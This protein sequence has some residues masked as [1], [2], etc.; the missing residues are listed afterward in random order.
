M[1][2]AEVLAWVVGCANP[3]SAT[4]T[5][6]LLTRM[7]VSARLARRAQGVGWAVLAVGQMA[8]LTFGLVSGLSGF[9]FAQPLMILVAGA[10]FLVWWS[11]RGGR[12]QIDKPNS[13]G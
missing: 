5:G 2:S 11:T 1:V 6:P 12:G 7:G 3:I 8:F 9:R 13:R 10:N 4:C